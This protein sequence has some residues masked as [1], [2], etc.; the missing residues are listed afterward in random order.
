MLNF[1][2]N[3][4]DSPILMQVI[5]V[6]C[7]GVMGKGLA[8]AFKNRYPEGYQ[9]Y[10]AMC[11][12]PPTLHC[13]YPR[14]MHMAKFPSN[15]FIMFPTKDD[16]HNPSLLEWVSNGLKYMISKYLDGSW[17][18]PSAIAFPPLGC[19]C[20]GLKWSDVIPL[21]KQFEIATRIPC[22]VYEL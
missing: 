3:L 17:S 18:K 14:P 9:I 22:T 1:R 11:F 13:G 15:D 5:P 7:V 2:G 10:H 16:W 12:R 20:G 6:N 21:I 19:G 4:L 8:L